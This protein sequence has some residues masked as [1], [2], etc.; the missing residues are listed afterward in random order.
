MK[1]IAVLLVIVLAS[2]FVFAGCGSGT[3]I[4][5][6]DGKISIDEEGGKV[7]LQSSGGDSEI[8]VDTGS[9]VSLPKGYPDDVLPVYKG[10]KIVMSSR[11][12]AN[13]GDGYTY[14]VS[15]T[16]KKDPATIY[17]YYKDIMKNSEQLGDFAS[18]G[19]YSI[20]GKKDGS[21]ISI[22][23]MSSE[24]DKNQPTMAILSVT[25]AK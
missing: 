8:A 1:K 17:E 15:F 22:L 13:S 23:I 20:S 5:T 12:K 4:D 25:A 2:A 10:G 6:G 3:T 11:N 7:K 16:S 14:S 9:G 18:N 24:E 19:T 21:D